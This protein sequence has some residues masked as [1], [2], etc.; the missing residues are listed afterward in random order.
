M[1]DREFLRGG[2][3]L[4]FF[5]G[6]ANVLNFVFHLSM[7]HTLDVADYGL[8]ATLLSIIYL[9]SIISE[10]VQSAS[11]AQ[12][13]NVEVPFAAAERVTKVPAE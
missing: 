1:L 8:L 2:I 13:A 7:A 6:I 3:I 12:P 11:P 10:S 4:T 9:L 5:F